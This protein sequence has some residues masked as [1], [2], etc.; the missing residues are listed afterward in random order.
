MDIPTLFYESKYKN[1]IVAGCDEV[2]RG[3]ISGCVVAS[4]VIL[5]NTN[6]PV[7]I[8]DSKQ[9][10]KTKRKLAYEW[11]I[12]NSVF[13]IGI[14][15]VEEID[16]INILQASL[17]AMK[18]AILSLKIKPDITLIDGNFI[19]Q[20]INALSI[21]KGDAKSLSIASASIIAKETRD[22]IMIDLS[23]KYPYYE[24]NKNM[25]YPTKNHLLAI[26]KY[27][28]TEYHRKTFKPVKDIINN[29]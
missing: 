10:S 5:T 17:L 26:K 13:S 29:I 12:T 11:L 23:K 14:S 1:K 21:I 6:I 7:L 15:T 24:W 18:R 27:G 4:A 25:G 28:I 22:K 16:K 20:G 2:G 8:A 9:L 19:P 3:P